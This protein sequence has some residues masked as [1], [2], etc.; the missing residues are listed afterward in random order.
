[1]RRAL[2]GLVTLLAACSPAMASITL[3]QTATASSVFAT[4][5]SVTFSSAVSTGDVVGVMVD[6]AYGTG[7][8]VTAPTATDSASDTAI[9]ATAWNVSASNW[10]TGVYLFVVSAG[11][12]S[13]KITVTY[14][15]SANIALLAFDYSGVNTSAPIDGSATAWST[16]TGT[17][18]STGSLTPGQT[19]DEQLAFLITGNPVTISG[20]S[21]SL[22]QAAIFA[23]TPQVALADAS[24]STAA[25]T[26]SATLSS[27]QPW[28]MAQLLLKPA[29]GGSSCSHDGYTAAGTLAVPN[30][31]SGSYW[32]KNGTLGT[33]NCSSVEYWQPTLGNFGVN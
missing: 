1:M 27:S 7:Q 4:S 16:G 21:G 14:T 17:A 33:P 6:S 15:S 2:L 24:V 28:G 13:F 23:I 22:T 29:S 25:V 5:N 26:A 11:S 20:W 31:T 10:C 19:G 8:C 12:S 3:V 9:A 32:L 30:G 18:V